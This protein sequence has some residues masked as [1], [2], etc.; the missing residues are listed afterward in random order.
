MAPTKEQILNNANKFLQKGQIDKAIAEYRNLLNIDPKNVQVRLKVGDLL[1]KINKQKEALEEFSTAAD[2]YRSMGFYPKAIAVYKQILRLDPSNI[3]VNDTLANLYLKIGLTGEAISIYRSLLGIYEK[4]KNTEEAVKV[5]KKI[6]EID[7]ANISAKVKLAEIYYH[8]NKKEEGAEIF[9]GIYEMLAHHKRED[10]MITILE[11]WLTFDPNNIYAVKNICEVYLK[12]HEAQRILLKLQSPLKEGIKD[13][14]LLK[15]LA[16]SYIL[17]NKKDKALPVFKELARIYQH[18]GDELAAKQ[19]YERVLEINPD[20]PEARKFLKPSPKKEEL[21]IEILEEEKPRP[22]SK[23]PPPVAPKVAKPPREVKELRKEESIN[24]KFIKAEVFI[25]YGIKK[26][27]VEEY[28]SILQIDPRNVKALNQLKDLYPSMGM[29]EKA[30]KHLI[31][32]SEIAQEN[33]E[34]EEAIR[35]LEEALTYSPDNKEVKDRLRAIS[36]EA[37]QEEPLLDELAEAESVVETK[38]EAPVDFNLEESPPVQETAET[39]FSDIVSETEVVQPGA[40]SQMETEELQ[41]QF[42]EVEFYVQQ[43]LTDEA[44]KILK[45]ILGKFPD[46]KKAQSRLAELQSTGVAETGVSSAPEGVPYGEVAIS[47]TEEQVGEGEFDLARELESELIEEGISP[48]KEVVV[49]EMPRQISAE[50]VLQEFKSKVATVVSMED[51]DT[52]YDLGIAYR[53]M[54]LIDEAISEF[55]ISASSP[56][57]QIESHNMLGLCY[58]DKGDFSEAE[59]YFKMVLGNPQVTEDFSKGVLYD[60][61]RLYEDNGNIRSAIETYQKISEIDSSFRDVSERITNLKSAPEKKPV[62]DQQGKDKTK[63]VSYI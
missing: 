1:L 16:E 32:L 42:D 41:E 31:T 18:G 21:E 12:R 23:V 2:T 40:V 47:G 29:G 45:D 43:G 8:T 33:G 51:A 62:E 55:K 48:Q 44:I 14:D 63:R 46:N 4:Q 7:P 57:K 20:D 36:P 60:L 24:E 13:P 17:L 59:K 37:I 35:Y 50:E 19:A 52:H 26:R 22:E 34:L 30:V 6:T 25:K 28:E 5:L 38:E 3:S 54:G 49:E 61:G 53:E 11:R 15:Y 58:R 39:S 9:K 27:A 56:H 10:D